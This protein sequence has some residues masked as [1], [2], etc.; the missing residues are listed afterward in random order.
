MTAPTDQDGHPI[1][2]DRCDET[3][4]ADQ[5]RALIAAAEREGE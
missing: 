2:W 4:L 1:C 3:L 5:L